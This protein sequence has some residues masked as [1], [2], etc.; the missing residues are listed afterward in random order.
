MHII[1]T[2]IRACSLQDLPDVFK[3]LLSSVGIRSEFQSRASVLKTDCSSTNNRLVENIFFLISAGGGRVW[4]RC[5]VSY[6]T[7]ASN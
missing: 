3:I 5:N 6:I 2:E 1:W 4:R 7:R